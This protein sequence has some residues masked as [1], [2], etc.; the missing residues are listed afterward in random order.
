MN[1]SRRFLLGGALSS[2]ACFVYSNQSKLMTFANNNQS[3]D[4]MSNEIGDAY[5]ESI[6][7]E[8]VSLLSFLNKEKIKALNILGNE[9][10][11]TN[12]FR[13]AL[14][15][16]TMKIYFPP[17][18]G[19]YVLN[20]EDIVL[21]AGFSIFGDSKKIYNVKSSESF[22]NSGT[23]I[24]IAKNSKRLFNMTGNHIFFGVNFDGLNRHNYF[25]QSAEKRI[26]NCKF[27]NCGFYRWKAGVG[28]SSYCATLSLFNCIITSNYIGVMNVIDSSIINSIINAN[29]AD[30]VRLMKGA[31]NNSFLGVRN[32]WNGATNYF[33]SGATQNIV[34][35]ELVDR[36][37]KN[38][39]VA[40]NGGS[41]LI[42]SVIVKRSGRNAD[43]GSNDSAHFYVDGENS[44]I[45]LSG[46]KTLAGKDDGNT[47]HLSPQHSLI[48]GSKGAAKIIIGS[49]DLTGSVGEPIIGIEKAKEK[50]IS[51]LIQ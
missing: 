11:I 28:N 48:I 39:F 27:I 30:G 37:G 51:G 3:V 49:S 5:K 36:A 50:S 20:G 9:V 13:N 40:L 4:A 38:G 19:I 26:K 31:N 22:N 25:M 33:S 8:N 15:K 35:G 42:N 12:E 18:K 41:W 2:L 24:R 1:I 17:Q 43:D 29:L 21:P 10:D 23:V 44:S 34:T 45:I 6:N 16:N 46:V 7:G 47:G 32:E 14:K